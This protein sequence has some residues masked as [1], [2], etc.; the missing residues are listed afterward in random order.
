MLMMAKMEHGRLKLVRTPTDI[1][2][3]V[4]AS[5]A[6]FQPMA[7]LKEINLMLQLPHETK[8]LLVDANLM[9]RV[10][11]NLL[12]N[13]LKFSPSAA[14]ITMQV[15]YPPQDSEK[16]VVICVTDE[17]PGVPEE[18]QETIFDKFQI[19]ASKRR[20]VS[21]V[22]LGLAF[23]K[24]VVDAHNGRI[25]VEPNTPHGAIFTVEI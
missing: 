17:G 3:M 24:M 4:T 19:V 5:V 11:D 25:F 18:H 2:Q 9:R 23:C 20:D 6:S 14:S 13:A 8:Q 21:Q 1:N 16:Q 12:S 15:E 10:L 22:G 7:G